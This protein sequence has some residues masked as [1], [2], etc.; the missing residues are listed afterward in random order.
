MSAV[1]RTVLDRSEIEIEF[2]LELEL[3]MEME[4]DT[5]ERKASQI[6]ATAWVILMR[7]PGTRSHTSHH[8]CTA[9]KRAMQLEWSGYSERDHGSESDCDWFGWV[10]TIGCLERVTHPFQ[11]SC[12]CWS[13]ASVSRRRRHCRR[14][15][16]ADRPGP[17]SSNRCWTIRWEVDAGLTSTCWR[18]LVRAASSWWWP[19]EPRR[20]P[21]N[22]QYNTI[23][24][25][26]QRISSTHGSMAI[27]R[28]G[29]QDRPLIRRHRS[30]LGGH[31]LRPDHRRQDLLLRRD[32][33]TIPTTMATTTTADMAAMDMGALAIPAL[34]AIPAIPTIPSIAPRRLARS[35]TNF[36]VPMDLLPPPFLAFSRAGPCCPTRTSST[37]GT[38]PTLCHFITYSKWPGLEVL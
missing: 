16:S 33:T 29:R 12:S 5:E 21:R 8:R 13:A 31:P 26:H 32:P 3:G 28:S 25:I 20:P 22:R 15:W 7:K 27:H 9:Y 38:T 17:K 36:P 34:E 4:M 18:P 23:T 10:R 2:E 19:R 35:I 14:A 1:I 11:L 6:W 37:A 24:I 30:V